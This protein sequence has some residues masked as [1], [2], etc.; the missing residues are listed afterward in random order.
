MTADLV[1]RMRKHRAG[2]GAKFTRG[3]SP[4]SVL[5]AKSFPSK[6]AAV[7]MEFEVK[8]MSAAAKR[9]LALAWSREFEIGVDVRAVFAPSNESLS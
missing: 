4:E 2:T 5:A 6:A 1:A 7:S 3:H 8:Q 9:V